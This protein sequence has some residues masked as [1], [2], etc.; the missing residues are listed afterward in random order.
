MLIFNAF[1]IIPQVSVPLCL[2]QAFSYALPRVQGGAES[3]DGDRLATGGCNAC[4]LA[5][6][7]CAS[8]V[9][10]DEEDIC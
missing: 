10:K 1:Y 5:S 9:V 7:Q 4:A 2:A 3:A 8:I 6:H